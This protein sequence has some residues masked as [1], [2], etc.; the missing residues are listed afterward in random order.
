[1]A[2][3]IDA[4][5]VDVSVRRGPTLRRGMLTLGEDVISRLAASP[6]KRGAAAEN[7]DGALGLKADQSAR[8]GAP[9]NGGVTATNG[10]R[11]DVPKPEL[12]SGMPRF[13]APPLE[14]PE[15]RPLRQPVGLPAPSPAAGPFT[16]L[17]KRMP[18]AQASIQALTPRH[19][20]R[21]TGADGG[22]PL[23]ED[24]RRQMERF[25]GASLGDVR[26]HADA[27]AAQVAANM[28]AEA[29]TI[30]QDIYFG[31]GKFDP[32]SQT[33]KA[34][35]GH[36]LTHVLQQRTMEPRRQGMTPGSVE[37][38]ET[39]AQTLARRFETSAADVS[40]TGFL[41][42]RYGCTYR[43]NRPATDDEAR[44]L[45]AL[46]RGA[47]KVCEEI[48]RARHPDLLAG[49]PR[50]LDTVEVQIDTSLAGNSDEDIVQAWGRRIAVA[51]AAKLSS[52]ST[53]TLAAAAG[54]VLKQRGTGQTHQAGTTNITVTTQ[55]FEIEADN[56]DGA[57]AAL[58]TLDEWGKTRWNVTYDYEETD[59]TATSVVVT[60]RITVELPRWTT[61]DKQPRRVRAEWNRMLAA[62]R[63]HENEHVRIARER[64]QTL[65]GELSGKPESELSDIHSR[66]LQDLD[67][68]SHA[69][70]TRTDHG[71]KQGVSL[72][73][74]VAARPRLRGSIGTR[75]RAEAEAHAVEQAML[76]GAAYALDVHAV[77]SRAVLRKPA[78]GPPRA[79][80]KAPDAAA[81]IAKKFPN[82]RVPPDQITLLQR[83]LDAR[84]ALKEIDE[85]PVWNSILSEDEPRKQA[86]RQEASEWAKDDRVAALVIPTENVLA[87]DILLKDEKDAKTQRSRRFREQLYAT[88]LTFPVRLV[89]APKA[90]E[91]E[92]TLKWGPNDWVLPNDGG[93][94]TFQN[95]MGIDRFNVAYQ[96]ALAGDQVELL[97][98]MAELT[99]FGTTYNMTG[100]KVGE[101][102]GY[103]WNSSYKVGY[104]IGRLTGY[105][106]DA[107][108]RAELEGARAGGGRIVLRNP[109]DGFLHVYQLD[110]PLNFRDLRAY[111]KDLLGNSTSGM[112][113]LYAK[114]AEVDA[115]TV[116]EIV[117][118]DDVL[119]TPGGD[120]YGTGWGAAQV[121]NDYEKFVEGA[122]LGD[123]VEDPDAVATVGQIVVGCIPIVGQVAD[124][125]DVLIGLHKI[126]ST[127]GKDGKI[128]TVGALVGFIPLLG[129]GVKSAW[130]SGR[131]LIKGPMTKQAA[132]ELA[133][134]AVKEGAGG[135][136]EPAAKQLAE[137][138][139]RNAD[140]VA[141]IFK[142]SK[143]EAQA[144]FKNLDDLRLKAVAGEAAAAK[145]FGETM[146]KK[147]D[148]LGGDAGTLVGMLG[149]SWE[150]V[151]KGLKTS[152][153]GALV[154]QKMERW[155]VAQF[156]GLDT[157]IGAK[158]GDIGVQTGEAA[159]HIVR[160]GTPSFAS[161]ADF[162]F[163]GPRSTQHR[164]AAIAIMEQRFGPNW[165]KLMDADIFSD[166]ARLHLFDEPLQKLGGQAAKDAGKRIVKTSELN[167]FAKMLKDGVPY[168]E[169]KKLATAAGV[170]MAEVAARQKEIYALSVDYIANELRKGTPKEALAEKLRKEGYANISQLIGDA[171]KHLL[172]GDQ[173]YRHLELRLDAL[174]TQF[175]MAKQAGD[176]GKQA[177][178]AEQ[179]AEIQGKLNAA[180][181][182][183]Y[184]TPGGGAARVSRRD[185]ELRKLRPPG[186]AMSPLLGYTAVL[187]DLYFLM[188]ALPSGE[189]TE[190]SAKKMAKYGDRVLVTA[191]QFGVEMKGSTRALFDD[192]AGLLERARIEK[193]SKAL[194]DRWP[195]T[196]G[197]LE[198]AKGQLNGQLT[199]IITAVKKNA[200][201]PMTDKT[202]STLMLQAAR[203]ASIVLRKES[204]ESESSQ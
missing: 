9:R 165:R 85:D 37:A 60:A 50:A 4:F 109:E 62:L 78:G 83:L 100:K 45:E 122:V 149:G 106:D 51:I 175:E 18:A 36:E 22:R 52:A 11:S 53:P 187:D 137:R 14:A 8:N 43:V 103:V 153:E 82:L 172:S 176:V 142:V 204:I 191:G 147:L 194:Q 47:L 190:G 200:A 127:G 23:D 97:E 92:L 178:I 169:V 108:G 42:N 65:A 201:D 197:F 1:M 155:R 141:E 154:G 24:T 152:P 84:A 35:L 111:D 164:N 115:G 48:L 180:I 130:K 74:N 118:A 179:M 57:A 126:W 128:Q 32:S 58:Q 203:I 146:S 77:G 95:L 199:Q 110:S 104:E 125:R 143:E 94:V 162:S 107:R 121:Q 136:A 61:L 86:L 79:K 38:L 19:P 158:I 170:D 163:L 67:T 6:S 25:F 120:S 13:I 17:F 183:P 119:L 34:L 91:P 28:A 124:A 49:A 167:V 96:A 33:G 173:L 15:P 156:D 88:M 98:G 63:R 73:L 21:S 188:H 150:D 135:V 89:I 145:E 7:S 131:K 54:T 2:L 68:L 90:L 113:F 198:Q 144:A 151:V 102:F 181:A 139:L 105:Y 44:R 46:S 93:K 161:D 56:L 116:Q 3:R 12:T 20:M 132:K 71:E 202:V 148:T 10:V 193:K 76:G 133:A 27:N 129:D 29:L 160:T 189:F 168:E 59:G 159:P 117:T 80:Y 166:P 123:A 40:G 30:G 138:A 171:E 196:V 185:L 99:R 114:G 69:F 66:C 64:I 186:S 101:T 184:V 72:D 41:V 75:E 195:M 87:G 5:D 26:V 55:T 177:Q 134:R 70:D 39:E 174:H 182:G 157:K 192:I 112:V 16:P 140:E 31:E 81:L